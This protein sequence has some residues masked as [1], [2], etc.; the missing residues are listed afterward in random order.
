MEREAPVLELGWELCRVCTGQVGNG[1]E[2]TVRRR[3]FVFTP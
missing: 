1:G 3:F 2:R